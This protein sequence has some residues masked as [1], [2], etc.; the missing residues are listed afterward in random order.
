MRQ[1]SNPFLSLNINSQNAIPFTV[2]SQAYT[3]EAETQQGRPRNSLRSIKTECYP[4]S[5]HK[6]HTIKSH[7]KDLS[8]SSSDS[9]EDLKYKISGKKF[10]LPFDQMLGTLGSSMIDSTLTDQLS[11]HIDFQKTVLSGSISARVG[12]VKPVISFKTDNSCEN[13]NSQ[14]IIKDNKSGISSSCDRDL[15]F[16]ESLYRNLFQGDITR[17]MKSNYFHIKTGNFVS[18]KIVKANRNYKLRISDPIDLEHTINIAPK[19]RSFCDKL[20]QRSRGKNI[21]IGTTDKSTIKK[22]EII[23]IFKISQFKSRA[24]SDLLLDNYKKRVSFPITETSMSP[25]EHFPIVSGNNL[26]IKNLLR[27][28]KNKPIKPTLS[29]IG[30]AHV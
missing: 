3:S 26:S 28:E 27:T 22:E 20:N 25:R 21:A 6:D 19:R 1:S 18:P 12:P 10:S 14:S 24:S 8:T 16:R 23:R 15:G 30:R 2:A 5:F 9:K 7:K 13:L 17:K 11:F 4:S 29:Q